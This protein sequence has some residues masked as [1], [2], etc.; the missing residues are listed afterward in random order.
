ME[1]QKEAPYYESIRIYK[2]LTMTNQAT[3][4]STVAIPTT[5]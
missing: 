4:C 2:D 1:P 3:K 5:F